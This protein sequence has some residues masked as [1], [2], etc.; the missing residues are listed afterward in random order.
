MATFEG[1][2]RRIDKINGVLA[3]YGFSDLDQMKQFTVDKG[4]DVDGIG[5]LHSAYRV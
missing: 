1:Y 4:L 3:E 5:S 2:D